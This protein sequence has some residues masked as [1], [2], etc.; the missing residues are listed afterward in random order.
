MENQT[1]WLAGRTAENK[2]T[3]FCFSNFAY[4][5]NHATEISVLDRSCSFLKFEPIETESPMTIIALI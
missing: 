4:E 2:I 3:D 1:E 5:I